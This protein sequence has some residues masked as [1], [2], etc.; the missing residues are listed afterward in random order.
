MRADPSAQIGSGFRPIPLFTAKDRA[1]ALRFDSL[2][3]CIFCYLGPRHFVAGQM[4]ARWGTASFIWLCRG[5]G[6]GLNSWNRYAKSLRKSA[7]LGT[8][9]AMNYGRPAKNQCSPYGWT[10]KGA[11]SKGSVENFL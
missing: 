5:S 3:Y 9:H 1:A 11:C 4:L 6:C 10:A 2:L 8:V 7:P